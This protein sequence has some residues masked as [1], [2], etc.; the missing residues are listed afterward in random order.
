MQRAPWVKGDRWWIKGV[1]KPS[2]SDPRSGFGT[3]VEAFRHRFAALKEGGGRN[4]HPL[5]SPIQ[6]HVSETRLQF[7]WPDAPGSSNRGLTSGAVDFLTSHNRWVVPLD[8]ADPLIGSSVRPITS[9]SHRLRRCRFQTINHLLPHY[10][11][12][13]SP[14]NLI[15]QAPPTIH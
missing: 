12:D 2:E 15:H 13:L 10:I 6:R 5:S 4:L 7:L 8:G 3:Q 14:H 11:I 1:S 9:R